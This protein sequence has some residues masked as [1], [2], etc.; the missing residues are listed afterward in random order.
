VAVPP[1]NSFWQEAL[2]LQGSVTPRV[3]AHVLAFGVVAALVTV[4]AGFA[5]QTFAVRLGLAVAPYE[6]AGAVLGLLLVLRT[7]AGYDRWWE[8]RKLWGG[9]VNQSR[10]MVLSALAYGPRDP[11]WRAEFV[12]WA[13]AFP[14]AARTLLRGQPFASEAVALVG[15]EAGTT[16]HPPCRVAR[17]LAGLLRE[18]R[19]R[20]GM[21]PYAFL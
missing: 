19:D 17:A 20:H 2:A 4:A 21:D 14:H 8:A 6:I 12:R 15:P 7:N 3:L 18:V 9:I 5:E 10:N 16:G 1:T 13:A 11:R